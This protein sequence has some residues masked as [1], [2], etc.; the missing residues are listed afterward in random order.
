MH[1]LHADTRELRQCAVVFG[2]VGRY[3][4]HWQAGGAKVARVN[5]HDLPTE[6]SQRARGAGARDSSAYDTSGVQ[7]WEIRRLAA[8][9]SPAPRLHHRQRSVFPSG[10]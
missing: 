3:Q 5:D 6:F 2:G 1:A 4:A 10:V 7:G 8:E 9:H